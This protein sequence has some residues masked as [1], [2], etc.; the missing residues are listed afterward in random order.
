MATLLGD[1]RQATINYLKENV[2][3]AIS[4]FFRSDFQQPQQFGFTVK[5]TN[6]AAAD[7]GIGL[8]N[9]RYQVQLNPGS[10]QP[11]SLPTLIVPSGGSSRGA[12]GEELN[13]GIGTDFFDFQP[14]DQNLAYLQIGESQSI[15]FYGTADRN[16]EATFSVFVGIQAD[17]D[18]NSIFPRNYTSARV[19][20]SG[21][22]PI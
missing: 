20:R 2:T 6:T 17:P 5:F 14:S 9:V 12:R 7:G 15:T 16:P 22:F 8:V 4:L 21:G 19:E 11:P 1:L 3:I 10:Y 18:L 13:I